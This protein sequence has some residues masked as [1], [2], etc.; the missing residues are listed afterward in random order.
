MAAARKKFN[1]HAQYYD[2]T[3]EL[4]LPW[5]WPELCWGKSNL[6]STSIGQGPND[7]GNCGQVRQ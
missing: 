4:E 7:N 3:G 5:S 6:A 2:D 1:Y